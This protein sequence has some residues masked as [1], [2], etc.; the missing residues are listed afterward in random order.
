MA[1]RGAG[2]EPSRGWRIRHQAKPAEACSRKNWLYLETAMLRR[3]SLIGACVLVLGAGGTLAAAQ[4]YPSDQDDQGQQGDQGYQ[5]DQGQPPGQGDQGQQPDQGYQGDQ[6]PPSDQGYQGPPRH[7][8]MPPPGPVVLSPEQNLMWIESQRPPYWSRMSPEGRRRYRD[9]L[10]RRWESMRRGEQLRTQYEMQKRWNRQP[11]DRKAR[12]EERLHGGGNYGPPPQDQGQPGDGTD[13]AQDGPDGSGP[14][15][16]MQGP[17]DGGQPQ[18][19][20]QPDDGGQPQDMQ[21]AGTMQM[22]SAGPEKPTPPAKPTAPAQPQ[23]L[24]G[25]G[26]D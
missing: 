7:G 20:Q 25:I 26:P 21:G 10:D 16:D 13:Q 4:S 3:I 1:K 2:R 19:M 24:P 14:P 8:Q 15:Q 9:S 6:G 17:D 22:Q 11:R 12:L 5:D 23:Q 18:D